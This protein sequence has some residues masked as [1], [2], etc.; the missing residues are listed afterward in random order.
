MLQKGKLLSFVL[1]SLFFSQ[2]AFSQ[3]QISGELRRWH[4]LTLTFNGVSTCEDA[5]PNPYTNFRLLVTFTKGAKNITVPGYFAA[6]GNAANTSATCGNKW[7]VHFLPDETGTWNYSVSYRSGT[8]IAMSDAA[9]TGTAITPLNG[10]SGSFVVQE[11]NKSGKDFRSKGKL[12]YTGKHHLQFDNGS[13]FLKGGTDSPE[14]FLAYWEFDGTFDNNSNAH[15]LQNGLHRYSTHVQDWNAGNPTWQS[16]EGKGIIGALNYLSEQGANSV[17]FLTMNID[18]DG[19]DTWPYTSPTQFDRF[20]V[21]KLAQWEIVF[22]HMDSLGL[23]LHFQTQE[24]ENQ[25]LLDNGNTG[26]MRKLYYRELIARFAHHHAV[27]WNLGEENG[28]DNSGNGAQNDQQRRDMAQYFGT[29]EPYSS[30]VT[31]H[32]YTGQEEAIFSPLLGNSNIDGMSIQADKN[33]ANSRAITWRERSAAAGRKWVICHDETTGGVDDDGAGNNYAEIRTKALWGA[34]MGGGGGVEWYFGTEDQ[35]AESF[36]T[37]AGLWR[38]TKVANDFFNTHVPFGEMEP[39][40]SLTSNTSDYCYVKPNEVYLIYLNNTSTTNINLPTG[41]Y[42]ISWFNPETGGSLQSGSKATTTGGNISIGNPPSSRQD[43]AVLIKRQGASEP[44][45]ACSVPEVTSL[46]LVR[47]GTA[48]DIGPLTNGTVIDLSTIG[49]F[50]I[51]ANTCGST[52]T[53]VEFRLNGNFARYENGAPYAI[54][55]DSPAGSYTAWNPTPGTY[56]LTV[57]PYPEMNG[58]GA[59]GVS[60]AVT[61]SVIEQEG[62]CTGDADCDDGNLCTADKCLSGQCID[63]PIDCDDD[64]QCT[65]D[66]CSNGVCTH[67]TDPDCGGGACTSPEVASVTLVRA[68]DGSEINTLTNGMVINLNT[69]G[70]FSL[71]ANAC[72]SPV[73]SVEF[74]LNGAM[75]QRESYAPYSINGDFTDG[76]YT[77][78]TPN[79]GSYTLTVIPYSGMNG[80]G[81]AG[82]SETINFTVVR[83]SQSGCTSNADCDDSNACTINAC[84]NNQ[85]VYT[86]INCADTDACT[87]DACV[88]GNCTHQADP[89]C[90]GSCEQ[91]EVVSFTVVR[92]T[93]GA[94]ITELTNGMTINLSSV[95]SFSI[96][97]DICDEPVGSVELKLNNAFVRYENFGPYSLRG[98]YTDGSFAPWTPSPGSYTITGI[99]YSGNNGNGNTGVSLSVSFTVVQQQ[100]ACSGRA[101]CN[102]NNPCTANECVNDQC[103]YPQLNCNDNDPCTVDACNGGTCVNTPD[104]NCNE[105]PCPSAC[106]DGN[107][108]TVDIFSQ[109]NCQHL[110]VTNTPDYFRVVNS[111]AS[112]KKLRIGY[113]TNNIWSPTHNVIAGGNNQVCLTIKTV[114]NPDWSKIDF[115]PQGSSGGVRMSEFIQQPAG[116]SLSEWTTVCIPLNRFPGVDFTRQ[117]M[118]EFPYSNSAPAFEIHI[119][120]IVYIG[121]STPFVWFGD[122]HT[123][124]I[125][126]GQSGGGSSL[127]A[128]IIRGAACGGSASKIS[129][130]QVNEEQTTVQTELAADVFKLHVYPVPFNNTLKLDITSIGDE[131]AQIRILDAIGKEVIARNVALKEGENQLTLDMDA[132]LASGVYLLIVQ[133]GDKKEQRKLYKSAE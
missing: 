36:R 55:G 86:P 123:N 128:Q 104:P 19:D 12:R 79:P 53:S 72:G 31:L 77:P 113:N 93:D 100:P 96:K 43:W 94:E 129:G 24:S 80:G 126:D 108:C 76:R 125:H 102:D 69:I 52:L 14:N 40:N 23:M 26:N 35:S 13:Y 78:W 70:S 27:T 121:G 44:P 90:N 101:Q 118:L 7:R 105:T 111:S 17:Y 37:R 5:S 4:K 41:D 85:C 110:T 83:Q 39:N 95:G 56:T 109:G 18:G 119:L 11:T 112:W 15:G 30:F 82:I 29:H 91:L 84:N 61:F 21:S 8:N 89:N 130:E 97:A 2:L 54:S 64:N 16:G 115:R 87:V 46:T 38:F 32:N 73:G 67:Q 1:L 49:E 122:N 34:Y 71:R 28:R 45:P 92:A 33:V 48:G 10:T 68:A 127:S 117:S 132:H 9:T 81:T 63:T 103:V 62:G 116:C 74:R 3:T 107:A 131:R 133:Q 106:A 88:N 50:S 66:G 99:P 42:T 124:N 120:K 114:G 75:V 51:R 22:A 59:A 6:D 20:D 65:I 58:N 98:D 25:N 60:Y 47:E 57:I